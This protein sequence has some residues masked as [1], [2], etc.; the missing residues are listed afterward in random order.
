MLLA[1]DRDVPMQTAQGWVSPAPV[2]ETDRG[3]PHFGTSGWLAHVDMPSLIVTSL[4]PCDAGEGANRAVCARFV[5]T[6]GYGG[7]AE[8]RFAR[9][10]SRASLIDATGAALQPLT[11]TGD[12]VQ[13][14]YSA[15]ETLRVKLEWE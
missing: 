14:E 4:V 12:A 15:N 8:M 5:E 9:D 2:V 6:S 1:T 3:P 11:L 10:P 7:A 13:I